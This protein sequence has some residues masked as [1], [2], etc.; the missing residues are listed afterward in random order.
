MDKGQAEQLGDYDHRWQ[1]FERPTVMVGG[2]LTMEAL[3]LR[4]DDNA[5]FYEGPLQLKANGGM[6]LIDDFG[7]QQMRPS[8][9]LNRWI[10]PLESRFDFLRLR[11]GQTMQVPFRQLI[12][13]STNL[14]PMQLVDEAFLRRIQMKV[15][16]DSPD[17]RMFFQIFATMC[18]K[19]RVPLDKDSFLY[20]LQ[21]WYRKPKR[22]FQSVHPRDIL[23]IVVA[24]CE[25]DGKPPQLSPQL[26]DD[27]CRSY[28]VETH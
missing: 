4:Y 19:M 5:K 3:D 9:L 23:K 26:I 20:L 11:T 2:E 8:D 28:F 27:A 15:G 24:L 12:V 18:Q 21:E 16:V 10:V 7:R 6:F 14:D 17:E 22:V 13:F 1:L 25:Y